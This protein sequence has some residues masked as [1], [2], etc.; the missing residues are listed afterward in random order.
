MG[1]RGVDATGAKLGH[2]AG[3]CGTVINHRPHNIIY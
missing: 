2:M 1:S 3:S